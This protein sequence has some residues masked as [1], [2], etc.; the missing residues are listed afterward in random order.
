MD[1]DTTESSRIL[2]VNF[3][4]STGEYFKIWVVNVALSI[5]TLGIYSA[6]AKVRT[7][8]YFYTHT[9]IEGA[10]FDYHAKPKAILVGRI[11]AVTLLGVYYLTSEYAPMVSLGILFLVVLLVPVLMVRSRSFQLRN[12]S[13][14]GIRFNF[15]RNFKGAFKTIYGGVAF[16]IV[17]LGLGSPSAL[18]WRHRFIADHSAYGK[19]KFKFF[20]ESSGFYGIFFA[21]IGLGLLAYFIFAI[22]VGGLSAVI[23]SGMQS[24]DS[25]ESS[26][27]LSELMVWATTLLLFVPYFAVG[28]YVQV[29]QRNYVWDNVELGGNQ[30]ESTLSVWQMIWMYASNAVAITA[31]LGLL[32]PWAKIRLARYRASQMAVDLRS[33]WNEFVADSTPDNSAIGDEIVG[34]FDVEVDVAF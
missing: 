14:N 8:R 21:S 34:A 16:S 3:N 26:G 33:D 9:S 23:S 11:I 25:W 1:T 5:V 20:G 22:F 2:S 32:I 17:T 10:T 29:A 12:T 31:S 15:E 24:G 18:F 4:G 27:A 7:M 6:W 19:T 30:F 13:F 28:I